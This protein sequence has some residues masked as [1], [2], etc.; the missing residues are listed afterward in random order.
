MA[1]DGATRF[2]PAGDTALIVEFGETIERALS[3]RVLG[4]SDRIRAQRIPGV[5]ETVPTFR[6]LAVHYDPLATSGEDLVPVLR[7]LME[8]TGSAPRVGR[9]WH[10]PVCYE[11]AYAPDLAEVADRT[12]LSPGEVVALHSGT[13]F[14]VYMLGFVPG[15]PYLGDVPDAL[16]LPRRTSPRV[17]V[18]PGSIAIATTL[19]AIYPLET[20]GGWHLIGK[21]P[22]RLFDP[23]SPRPALFAP[24]D[25]IRFEPVDAAGF[26]AV[27]GA[28]EAGTYSVPVEALAP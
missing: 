22:I 25:A 24:G 5:I 8:E 18:P 21:T 27:R 20:P 12:G 10:V 3:D 7:H 1:S 26:E 13:R 19:T 17:R 15:F 16:V 23:A 4:L 28:V 9:L 11:A 2:L 14:H 6:S